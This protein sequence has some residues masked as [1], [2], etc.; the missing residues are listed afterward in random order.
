VSLLLPLHLAVFRK[1]N[2]VIGLIGHVIAAEGKVAELAHLLPLN[3]ITTVITNAHAKSSFVC[4]NDLE[5]AIP[6]PDS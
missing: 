4:Y 2:T 5:A 3:L 6:S 1:R